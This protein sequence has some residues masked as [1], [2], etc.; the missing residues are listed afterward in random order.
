[1]KM[2]VNSVVPKSAAP[3]QVVFIDSPATGDGVPLGFCASGTADASVLMV[4]VDLIDG[5]GVRVGGGTA[6]VS[7]GYWACPLR[8]PSNDPSAVYEVRAYNAVPADGGNCTK[9]HYDETLPNGN[10]IEASAASDDS[11]TAE[12]LTGYV[13]PF[14]ITYPEPKPV[15]DATYEAIIAERNTP[16]NNR[17]HFDPVFTVNP[18]KSRTVYL[19]NV[20]PGLYVVR[21]VFF[22]ERG[23]ARTYS[24]AKRV[25]S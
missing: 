1:M 7:G 10:C 13:G 22:T 17:F 14:A 18:P 8:L 4:T 15:K 24:L 2:V 9:L 20:G 23:Q 19:P 11:A 12:K 21:F 6:A 16:P 25:S 3:L 5:N